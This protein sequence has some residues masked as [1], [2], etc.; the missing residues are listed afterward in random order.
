MH[1]S[2]KTLINSL[3]QK[4]SKLEQENT[5]LKERLVAIEQFNKT[6]MSRNSYIENCLDKIKK[7]VSNKERIRTAHKYSPLLRQLY[8]D[9]VIG[10]YEE[11]KKCLP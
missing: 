3:I 8:L 6:I 1:L 9:S 2:G 11:I 5:L 4:I 10:V 7:A